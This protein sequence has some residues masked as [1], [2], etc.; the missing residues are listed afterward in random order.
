MEHDEVQVTGGLIHRMTWSL[1]GN[2]TPYSLFAIHSTD[3]VVVLYGAHFIFDTAQSAQLS[4]NI[5]SVASGAT[6]DIDGKAIVHFYKC[7]FSYNY[8]AGN[9]RMLVTGNYVI[10]G[11]NFYSSGDNVGG[12]EFGR[13]PAFT[14]VG[15]S[16]SAPYVSNM[17]NR[18]LIVGFSGGGVDAA[19][20]E[21]T[22]VFEG[23]TASAVAIYNNRDVANK[24]S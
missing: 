16:L 11:F 24:R 22:Y 7:S 21:W 23:L 18:S 10:E 20:A 14:P 17:A 3:C 8:R 9:I 5:L 13:P 1:D 2:G 6:A 12:L 15:L 19:N 4:M